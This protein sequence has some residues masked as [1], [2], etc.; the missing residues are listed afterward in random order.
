MFA[1]KV[2]NGSASERLASVAVTRLLVVLHH[3]SSRVSDIL[4]RILQCMVCSGAARI[5]CRLFSSTF[6]SV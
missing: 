6:S 3:S 4:T 2:P 1:E 5:A